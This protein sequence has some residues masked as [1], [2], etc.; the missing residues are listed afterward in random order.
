MKRLSKKILALIL[1]VASC[2]GL[3]VFLLAFTNSTKSSEEFIAV[4]EGLVGAYATMGDM[5]KYTSDNGLT[6]SISDAELA[7]QIDAYNRQVDQ[8]Y[9]KENSCNETY[10]A[11]NRYYLENVCKTKI[12]QTIACCASIYELKGID[13]SKDNTEATISCIMLCWTKGVT[14]DETTGKYQAMQNPAGM[15]FIKAK[16]VKEDGAWKLL[17]FLEYRPLSVWS[18]DG[19]LQSTVLKSQKVSRANTAEA[20][21]CQGEIQKN[22]KIL[23]TQYNTYQEAR[24]AVA[25]MDMEHGNYF[26]L[27]KLCGVDLSGICNAP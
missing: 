24:G 2:V 10:K 13:F 9:A 27:A 3:S 20:E 23:N 15:K 16:M 6:S 26:A 25:S 14:T 18:S 7:A 1:V 5:G 21:T 8:Y 4:T 22:E 17:D 11:S 19:A 12:D